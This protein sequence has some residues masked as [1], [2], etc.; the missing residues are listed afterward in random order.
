MTWKEKMKEFGGGDFT[1]ISEDGETLTFII[2]GD[3]VLLQAKFKGNENERV[4]CP[5][6]TDDGY[7]LF[8]TGKRLARKLS[9]FESKFKTNALMVTRHGEAGDINATYTVTV[10]LEVETFN[11][12]KALVKKDMTKI[13]IA[14][15]IE[16]VKEVLDN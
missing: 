4:G 13:M 16:A 6:M 8:V 1:F 10:I 11:R 12:L 9:K 5:V 7:Q 3:P 2:V 15:S 14:D